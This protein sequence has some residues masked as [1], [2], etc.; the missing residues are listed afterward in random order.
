MNIFITGSAGFIGSHLCEALLQAGHSVWGL[1]NFNSFY[2][3]ALKEANIRAVK[4]TAEKT[5]SFF[6]N[7]TGDITDEKLLIQI[8]S[9][10]KMDVVVHLAAMAGVRPSFEN[11]GLYEKVNGQGTVNILQAMQKTGTK[12]LVFASSSSVYG[13]NQKI[14][15]CED[16]PIQF[17]YS[18]YAATKRANELMCFAFHRAYHL[19]IASLRFFTVYGP[20]QRPDLAIRNFSEKMVQNQPITIFGDGSAKRDFTYIDDIIDGVTKSISWVESQKNPVYEI[21]NLGESQTTSVLELVDLLEKNLKIKA[22]KIFKP[23]QVG[24]VPITFADISKPKKILGYNPQTKIAEGIKKFSEWL[25]NQ[26]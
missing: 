4:K 19:S 16:D 10:T 12:N 25:L 1:D 20:R 17:T 22:E 9:E 26:S 2:N 15:F 5:K 6:K 8:L 24:D 3:P 18:P 23:A 13:L 14:P 11:P 21:F 7:M